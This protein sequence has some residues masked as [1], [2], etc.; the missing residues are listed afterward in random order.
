MT[1]YNTFDDQFWIMIAGMVLAV[2]SVVI[3]SR[4]SHLA[5]CWGA[6]E[7][8]R[9]INAEVQLA[10]METTHNTQA[11]QQ[12]QGGGRLART[13][14]MP[15]I[16]GLSNLAGLMGH[17]PPTVPHRPPTPGAPP[18]SPARSSSHGS[19]VSN[20]NITHDLHNII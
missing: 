7:I 6:C 11:Q 3:K 15:S 14:T 16:P 9:D 18:N 20:D 8:E 12:A 4:C 5:C 10:R 19:H 1:W 2:L 13:S 17:S